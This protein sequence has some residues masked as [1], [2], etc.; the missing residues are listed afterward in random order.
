M[1]INLKWNNDMSCCGQKRA[2]LAADSSRARAQQPPPAAPVPIAE[3]PGPVKSDNVA[4]RYLGKGPISL[5]GPH[6]RRAYYF[7]EKGEATVVDTKDVEALL[8][9]RLFGIVER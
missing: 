7:N 1:S 3:A 5:R 2:K 9:T 8:R 6:T 4:L